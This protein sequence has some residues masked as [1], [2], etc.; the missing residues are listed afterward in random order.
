MDFDDG[1]VILDMAL[2]AMCDDVLGFLLTMD[3]GEAEAQ[4]VYAQ[5][6]SA[7][8]AIKTTDIK[9]N[10]DGGS[11]LYEAVFPLD[12]D[13][14]NKT[15]EKIVTATKR[16]ENAARPVKRM[17]VIQK[18]P[19]GQALPEAKAIIQKYRNRALKGQ[20]RPMYLLVYD[21]NGRPMGVKRL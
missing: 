20:P 19:R 4:M 8:E 16:T 10:N 6:L 15:H 2:Q 14:I 21:Y 13:F 5:I 11:L 12:Q 17:Q 7:Y 3:F 1:A 9:E 18:V